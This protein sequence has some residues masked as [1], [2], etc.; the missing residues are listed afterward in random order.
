MWRRRMRQADSRR[1]ASVGSKDGIVGTQRTLP[2]N[3]ERVPVF[4]KAHCV[5]MLTRRF[6]DH[7]AVAT[8]SARMYRL[9]RVEAILV[10]EHR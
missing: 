7:V 2:E 5:R 10:R 4:G 8:R 1:K 3:G 9:R 6:T